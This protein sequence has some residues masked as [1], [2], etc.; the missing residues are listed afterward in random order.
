MLL[1]LLAPFVGTFLLYRDKVGLGAP[2]S[3]A[4]ALASGVLVYGAVIAVVS[5]LAKTDAARRRTE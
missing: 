5:R 2:P 4:A 1:R 3:V